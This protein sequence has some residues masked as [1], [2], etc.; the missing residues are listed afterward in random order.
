M[1]EKSR[2]VRHCEVVLKKIMAGEYR[3][4][5]EVACDGSPPD[6]MV[7]NSPAHG[8]RFKDFFEDVVIDSGLTV[9]DMASTDPEPGQTQLAPGWPTPE[10]DADYLQYLRP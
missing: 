5:V 10:A 9:E 7:F 8:S 3:C 6:R 1:Q 4:V 2:M